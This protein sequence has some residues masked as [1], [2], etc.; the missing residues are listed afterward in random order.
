MTTLTCQPL[1]SF[2][3]AVLILVAA[4]GGGL[5]ARGTTAVPA[6]AWAA[7][8]AIVFGIEMGCRAAGLLGDPSAAAALRLVAVALSLCPTMAL[9]GAKRPQHGVWQFIVA[10]LA[11]VLAMPA[12]SATLVRPGTMPDVHPLQRWFMTLLV[13]VG[14]MN[15]AATRHGLAAA[16]VAV[17]Q[18]LLLRPFLPF[19]AGAAGPITDGAGAI[20]A[21]AGA[22]LAVVQSAAWP[23]VPRSASAGWSGSGLVP[24]AVDPVAVIGGPFVAL[25]ETLGAAWTLRIADRFNA[26]AETRGWPCRLRFTG[27]EVGGD[28]RDDSWHR[29]AIR[30]GRALLRRFVSDDW[31]AR[32]GQRPRLPAKKPPEVAP[33]AEGR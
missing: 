4:A 13:V 32:H 1:V 14:W 2:G 15:F 30:G 33:A 31:L 3:A 5:A 22:V 19:A 10:S 28:P 9:L 18:V 27:L 26:V 12:V 7:A 23:A 11:F 21:A 6:A 16:L 20:L 24:A 29:D 17:G 8:A 25:R